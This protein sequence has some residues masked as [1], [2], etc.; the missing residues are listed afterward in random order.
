MTSLILTS[1]QTYSVQRRS[2]RVGALRG[3]GDPPRYLFGLQAQAPPPSSHHDQT[4]TNPDPLPHNFPGRPPS[5]P[6]LNPKPPSPSPTS[7]AQ[8][9]D[10]C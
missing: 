3:A 8:T 10:Q 5:D 9:H 6:F 7:V 4:S 1:W 2:P